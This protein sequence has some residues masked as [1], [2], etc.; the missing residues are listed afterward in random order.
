MSVLIRSII[1]IF[2]I[3]FTVPTAHANDKFKKNF[4]GLEVVKIEDALPK[5]VKPPAKVGVIVS[6]VAIGSPAEKSGF[7]PGFLIARVDKKPVGSPMQFEEAL[8]RCEKGTEILFNVYGTYN[9]RYKSAVI[10]SQC[11][12]YGDYMESVAK[13]KLDAFEPH[14]DVYSPFGAPVSRDDR[15]NR[16]AIALRSDGTKL[17]YVT[18]FIYTGREYGGTPIIRTGTDVITVE[19][20]RVTS[21]DYVG[22]S[23]EILR[24]ELTQ[25]EIDSIADSDKLFVRYKADALEDDYALPH[26]VIADVRF[27]RDLKEYIELDLGE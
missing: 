4:I 24:I 9:G 15:R 6:H 7:K 8:S 21:R 16:I 11:I 20:D 22:S 14:T 10:K 27:I 17:H 3:L 13:A 18:H 1:C 26:E 12:S 19:R 23:T 5:N 25:K 2:V